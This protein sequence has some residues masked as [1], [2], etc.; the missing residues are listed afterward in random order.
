MDHQDMGRQDFA[1]GAE[2]AVLARYIADLPVPDLMPGSMDSVREDEF[3]GHRIVVRT[4]YEITVDDRAVTAHLMVSN[5][6]EVHCH[7]LPAYQFLSAVDTVKALI[8]YFPDEFPPD[9]GGHGGP[10]GPGGDDGGAH[11]GHG[12]E[13]HHEH[14]HG[15]DHRG[16]G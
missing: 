13:H 1:A 16:G 12:H 14:G 2:P 9:A 11:E 6:G 10:A 8:Q 3:E 5:N 7:A 15:P 4:R